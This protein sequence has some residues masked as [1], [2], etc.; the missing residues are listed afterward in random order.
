MR[1]S[2]NALGVL[3]VARVGKYIL[4][5]GA[6]LFRRRR[7]GSKIDPRAAPGHPRDTL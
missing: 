1:L 7:F 6:H 2:L 4:N 5:S 3:A